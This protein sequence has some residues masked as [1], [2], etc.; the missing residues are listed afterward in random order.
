MKISVKLIKIDES[1]SN[2]HGI[3]TGRIVEGFIFNEPTIGERFVVFHS[4]TKM[5]RTSFVTEII[6]DNEFKTENSTY[7]WEKI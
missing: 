5:F 1:R 2:P 3:K 7:T 4:E 6:S